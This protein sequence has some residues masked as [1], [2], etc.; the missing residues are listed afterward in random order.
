MD[1]KQVEIIKDVIETLS[2]SGRLREAER[3]R[4]ALPQA[5]TSWKYC[6]F[7]TYRDSRG[8]GN[9]YSSFTMN[10][11]MNTQETISHIIEALRVEHKFL[12]LAPTNWILLDA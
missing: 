8:V 5:R 11:P 12:E 10:G 6:V 2:D 4:M 9:G 3:L 7:Y 1:T